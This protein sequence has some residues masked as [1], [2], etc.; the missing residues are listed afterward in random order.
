MTGAVITL[1]SAPVDEWWH[2]AFGRD[3]VLWSPPH[4]AAVAG[5]I[6]LGTGVA[7]IASTKQISAGRT[8]VR[9][10]AG[11]G[12]VGAWQVLVLEYDT[13]VAQFSSLWY[14]PV[15]AAGLAAAAVTAQAAAWHRVRWPATS[16]GVVYTLAMAGVVLGL[17]AADFSTPIVPLVVPALIVA[18]LG[19]RMRWAMPLRV[20]GFVVPLFASYWPYLGTVSGGCN[21]RSLKLPSAPCSPPQRSRAFLSRR[22]RPPASP[23]VAAQSPP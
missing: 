13:D 1:G 3:A 7:L 6:A 4:L 5:T 11:A 15:M 19:W 14:L 23:S 8:L 17:N 18:D 20:L 16:A 12:V 22:F 21:P 9:A 2:Q 10:A